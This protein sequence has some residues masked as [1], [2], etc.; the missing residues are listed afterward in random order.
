MAPH[1]VPCAPPPSQDAA[2]VSL[3]Q[4][5]VEV[6]TGGMV[7]ADTDSGVTL[8]VVG[9]EGSTG[10]QVGGAEGAR[11]RT[12]WGQMWSRGVKGRAGGASMYPTVGQVG[13]A[14][15]LQG[16]RGGASMYP[17]GGQ[18]WGQH[19]PYRGSEVGPACNLQGVR[20]GA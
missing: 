20:G 11:G 8:E 14:C 12:E 6:A 19:V 7:D 4:Y 1:P 2:S 13:P 15:T 5:M 17:T 3:H 18:R 10:R 16:V 9:S